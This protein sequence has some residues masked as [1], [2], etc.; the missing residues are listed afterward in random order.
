M[1]DVIV[2]GGGPIGSQVAS[3]L[4]EKDYKV[5]VLEK[6]AE[7]GAKDCCTGII[8]RECVNLFKIDSRVILR[9][10]SSASLFSPS[11][12]T[13][14]LYREE[15][16]AVALDRTAFNQF[17]TGRAQKAGAEFHF[18]SRAIDINIASDRA[19][20]DISNRGKTNQESA[21]VIVIA[22]GFNPGLN[23]RV[24]LGKYKDYAVGIQAD[25]ETPGLEEVEICFGDVA[26]GFF[27][28]LVPTARGRGKA[29]L[30]SRAEP[31]A[32]LKNW[33]RHLVERGKIVSDDVK[34]N[35]GG[36]PL[37]P[38]SRTYGERI[39]AVGDAAGQVKPT[40]GGGIYY[41]LLG[42]ETAAE[43]LHR[44]LADNELSAKRL[45]SYERAWRK[46]LGRELRMGY[47]ARLLFEKMNNRQIDRIFKMIKAGGIDE[48]LSKTKEISFDW[49][50]RTIVSLLKYQMISR[51]LGRVKLPFKSD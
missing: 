1:Y 44:A 13:I 11:G 25:V 38:P 42:A 37:K 30:I 8:S 50:S 5:L 45:A 26:P 23:E 29:G 16:Q 35:Y 10:L 3:R 22:S 7:T 46:Q 47:W 31:G 21:K 12:N 24:G 40:T 34:L 51:A 4:A 2:I 33:L 20:V 28:W 9:E 15:S 39:I 48:A 17:M 19:I 27:S 36:I 43:I 14:Y 32:Y 41:G 18:N 6:K 49:H